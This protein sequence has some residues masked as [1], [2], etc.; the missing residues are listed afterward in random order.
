M[1]Q[2]LMTLTRNDEVV[3]SIPGSRIW[4]C[5]NCGAGR[6]L[7]SNPRLLW[8]WGN[9]VATAPIGP[10]VWEPLYA[11]GV[12][13]LKRQKKKKYCQEKWLKYLDPV[14]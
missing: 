4:H 8:L 5:Q 7:G 11:A 9:Q 1:A 3:G 6:S 14:T 13:A 2:W 12:T 10:L